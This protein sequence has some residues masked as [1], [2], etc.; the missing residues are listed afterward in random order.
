[1][2][3]SAIFLKYKHSENVHVFNSGD[4]LEITQRIAGA[5]VL[6]YCDNAYSNFY[7]G[8]KFIK[9]HPALI[10]FQSLAHELGH[11]VMVDKYSFY[12]SNLKDDAFHEMIG[13]IHAFIFSGFIDRDYK[14]YLEDA[15]YL[16][17]HETVWENDYL[18]FESHDI[19]RA[20]LQI[21]IDEY[22]KIHLKDP[23]WERLLDICIN[24]VNQA[25]YDDGSFHEVAVKILMRYMEIDEQNAAALLEEVGI[26]DDSRFSDINDEYDAVSIPAPGIVNR[27]FSFPTHAI[28][29]LGIT[30]TVLAGQGLA[31]AA[32]GMYSL[33]THQPF[34]RDVF[35]VF[36]GIAGT[37]SAQAVFV[38]GVAITTW[39]ARALGK[40]GDVAPF[41]GEKIGPFEKVEVNS[42]ILFLKAGP[43]GIL[44]INPFLYKL[45]NKRPLLQFL[46]LYPTGFAAHELRHMLPKSSFGK[47]EG[48][49]R[50][51]IAELD[52]FSVS[53]LLPLGT[54]LLAGGFVLALGASAGVAVMTGLAVAGVAT[55][56]TGAWLRKEFKKT[57]NNF[58]M[59]SAID[60]IRNNSK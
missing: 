21:I 13:D 11:G 32:I 19:A 8:A 28:D 52:A 12:I 59:N 29:P 35:K 16:W 9:S 40:K 33:S 14:D 24:E 43:D 4:L 46:A 48:F 51:F 41:M 39:I 44:R 3:I 30:L 7:L 57:I 49:F 15:K 20:F 26:I 25:Y 23:D 60:Q 58:S 10:L 50:R 2:Y 18:G 1:M 56:V 22:R 31:F 17:S 6:T 34:N 53:H 38:W 45:L 5:K 47:A 27:I 42:N 36:S 37:L 55:G 54:G